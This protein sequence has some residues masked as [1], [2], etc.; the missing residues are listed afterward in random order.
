MRTIKVEKLTKEAFAPFGTYYDYANPDGYALCGEIHKFY[1]DRLTA[2]HDAQVGFSPIVVK[3]PDQMKITQVEYHTR[4]AELIMPLND[5]MIVHVAQPS[6]G[7]PIPEFTKAFL[8]PKNTMIKM[9]ACVWHLAPL[10][11]NEK[12]LNALIILPECC[13]IN[14]CTVVDLKED[15]QFIIEK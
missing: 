6:A 2:Y 8:V 7:K 10:P 14:D 9:N 13:Y 1:P 11:A 15:E 12:Q 5:D 3:K 4:S